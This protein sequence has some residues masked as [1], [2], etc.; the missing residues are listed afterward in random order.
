MKKLTILL[1]SILISFNSYSEWTKVAENSFQTTYT[2]I[3]TINK[4]DE[5]VYFWQLNN[6]I[7]P[8]KHGDMS[9]IIYMQVDCTTNRRKYLSVTFYSQH[10]GKGTSTSLS[11]S[12]IEISGWYY[13]IPPGSSAAAFSGHACNYNKKNK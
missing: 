7:K 9:N 13:N 11:P 12:T 3:S 1:F 5:Y 6:N 10:Y 8:D 2:D 4:R